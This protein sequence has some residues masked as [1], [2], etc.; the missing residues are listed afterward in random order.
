MRN[1]SGGFG[2]SLAGAVNSAAAAAAAKASGLATALG[3]SAVGQMA[4]KYSKA[5][6]NLLD[7]GF[8]SLGYFS[9]KDLNREA[10]KLLK[11]DQELLNNKTISPETRALAAEAYLEKL[12]PFGSK[13]REASSQLLEK[14]NFRKTQADIRGK[15][16]KIFDPNT[17][18]VT[19]DNKIY[20]PTGSDVFDSV[21]K[22][23]NKAI[24]EGRLTPEQGAKLQ[25]KI[26]SE[27]FNVGANEYADLLKRKGVKSGSLPDYLANT[28]PGLNLNEQLKAK[29]MAADLDLLNKRMNR[30]V[31]YE[32]DPVTGKAVPSSQRGPNW[33]SFSDF[34]LQ[35]T[36]EI[37][38]NPGLTREEKKIA[39]EKL[40]MKRAKDE[41]AAKRNFA[42]NR[43]FEYNSLTGEAVPEG[44]I[45]EAS[46][47]RRNDRASMADAQEKNLGKIGKFSLGLAGAGV[48]LGAY[49]AYEQFKEGNYL[50]GSLSGFG[51]L[52]SLPEAILSKSAR[53][54]S[55]VE[56]IGGQET[57]GKI[58]GGAFGIAGAI[59]SSKQAG[60]EF[61]EG[62]TG[63]GLYS[64]LQAGV[65]GGAG[66]ASIAGQAVMAQRLFAGGAGLAFARELYNAKDNNFQLISGETTGAR[67]MSAL[68]GQ[69]FEGDV[70][71]DQIMG[72][73]GDIAGSAFTAGMGG[74]GAGVTTARLG[75]RLGNV[76][77]QSLDDA[78][79]LSARASR[80]GSER[81]FDQGD[82]NTIEDYKE[83]L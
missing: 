24:S 41:A 59:G 20:N 67:L 16:E 12:G 33:I 10:V 30:S 23:I 78:L 51:A 27:T 6:S 35:R 34:V 49:G 4:R 22:E 37:S 45:A 44:S 13:V 14:K 66:I 26:Y 82:F 50:E 36:K 61:A 57:L 42:K 38:Q 53:L 69:S 1:Q 39:I 47:A 58:A 62:K 31:G 29:G 8:K 21:T 18:K 43:G 11:F 79:G 46:K 19:L 60:A 80:Y 40:R 56:K 32:F 65:S 15:F 28:E 73:I 81:M 7:S 77:E 54:G 5:G 9:Q 72:A 74:I 70:G 75:Y 48:G 83:I 68:T 17:G 55:L 71:F 2:A 63:Q 25:S 76:L 64:T 52:A 3:G